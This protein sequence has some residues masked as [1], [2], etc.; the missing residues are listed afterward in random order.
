MQNSNYTK[1]FISPSDSDI[2]VNQIMEEISIPLAKLSKIAHTFGG[3]RDK[4][5]FKSSV[6]RRSNGKVIKK[7]YGDSHRAFSSQ[8]L[9]GF[10]F[11]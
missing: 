3:F 4:L 7:I 8:I 5:R 11:I 2:S 9:F 1:P 10:I 6:G